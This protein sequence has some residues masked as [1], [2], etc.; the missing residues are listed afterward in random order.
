MKIAIMTTLVFLVMSPAWSQIFVHPVHHY[1]LDVPAGW[2]RVAPQDH[3]MQLFQNN[4]RSL[5]F[6]VMVTPNATMGNITFTT[7]HRE[8]HQFLPDA[9]V[10]DY[11]EFNYQGQRALL[12]L[13]TLTIDGV[14]YSGNIAWVQGEQ[15]DYWVFGST[16]QDNYDTLLPWI[17]S[18]IDS[19]GIGS[20]SRFQSGLVSSYAIAITD[21]VIKTY[22]LNFNN[23]FISLSFNSALHELAQD[24]IEREAVIMATY[25]EKNDESFR[26]WMRYYRM[27]HRDNYQH[28]A[29]LVSAIQP[30]IS[31]TPRKAAEELLVFSQDFMYLRTPELISDL[32]APIT[33]A[34]ERVGDCDSMSLAYII[35][36]NHF[37]IDALLLLTQQRAHAITAVQVPGDNQESGVTWA[38]G[39]RFIAAELTMREPLGVIPDVLHEVNDW[40]PILFIA[41]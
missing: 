18:A 22:Q 2:Y 4:E 35:L 31:T 40:F 23:R 33:G 11:E 16:L 15:V 13:F 3:D 25:H 41:R 7:L 20:P 39:R 12:G 6:G 14:D 28:F 19:F 8:V 21:P 26:A 9:E 32:I 24:V 5:I 36:L 30:L 37:D 1:Q 38:D 10:T 27:I 29:P 34:L 17:M